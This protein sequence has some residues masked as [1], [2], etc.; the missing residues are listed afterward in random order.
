MS[1]EAVITKEKVIAQLTSVTRPLTQRCSGEWDWMIQAIAQSVQTEKKYREHRE[2]KTENA[3]IFKPFQVQKSLRSNRGNV[4]L[5][6]HVF[7][8][9]LNDLLSRFR[10]E[11]KSSILVRNVRPVLR[12]SSRERHKAGSSML[13]IFPIAL[14]YGKTSLLQGSH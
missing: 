4:G 10:S 1:K 3:Y 8:Y 11:P 13:L 2:F 9:T 7:F 6:W 5:Y 14:Y 12:N